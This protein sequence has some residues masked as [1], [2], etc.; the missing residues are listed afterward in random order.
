MP[1]AF[2]VL[3]IVIAWLASVDCR[4][5][6]QT[7]DGTAE[8]NKPTQSM[9]DAAAIACREAPTPRCVAD[10]AL[11]AA[12]EIEDEMWR[13]F[14]FSLVVEVYAKSGDIQPVIVV[15]RKTE[16]FNIVSDRLHSW[17]GRQ[18]R[19]TSPQRGRHSNRRLSLLTRLRPRCRD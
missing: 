2:V 9:D 3:A 13:D 14:L 10:L 11:A 1:R 12:A 7:N 16:T 4:A 5:Y 6:A 18:G 8:L 19:S 17:R 15:A